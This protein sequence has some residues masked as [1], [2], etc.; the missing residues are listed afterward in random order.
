MHVLINI[1]F[2]CFPNGT[3]GVSGCSLSASPYSCD[4]TARLR[5]MIDNRSLMGNICR[6]SR[7]R[8]GRITRSD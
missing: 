4:G 1:I 3:N 7:E 5:E 6:K 2:W 8:V